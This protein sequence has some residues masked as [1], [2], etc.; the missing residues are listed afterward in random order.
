MLPTPPRGDAVSVG[1]RPENV[2]LKRTCTSPILLACKRTFLLL[3]NP[4]FGR[5]TRE[6]SC[7]CGTH[8]EYDVKEA[9]NSRIRGLFGFGLITGGAVIR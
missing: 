1:Y 9:A 8:P 7:A 6:A 3:R 2:Y 5:A 4:A